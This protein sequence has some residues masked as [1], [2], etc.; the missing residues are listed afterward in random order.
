ME[1]TNGVLGQNESNASIRYNKFFISL[2]PSDT[3]VQHR[4]RKKCTVINSSLKIL[5]YL[6]VFNFEI[7]TNFLCVVGGQ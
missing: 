3:L 2:L 5:E 1:H 4:C 7:S 6:F